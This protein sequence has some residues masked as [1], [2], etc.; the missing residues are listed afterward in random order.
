MER[1]IRTMADIW[2]ARIGT[3]FGWFWCVLYALA[4]VVAFC[5]LP[6]AKDR[7]DIAM[8]FI[9]IGLA[10]V[11]FLIVRASR[12]TRKLVCDFRIYAQ[13][14]ADDKSISALSKNVGEPREEVEKK[15]V[16]MCRRG[17]FKG[18]IDLRQECL[19]LDR[20]EEAVAARCP[21]CGATSRIYRTGGS[22]RYCGNPLL[23]G[24]TQEEKPLVQM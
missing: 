24:K 23:P 16:T 14:L 7:L 13:F 19:V 15:L 17:Y 4:A 5:D 20:P 11:H 6:D 3:A 1:R 18:K 9:C 12:Q 2:I 21:A 22:C 8:P 10:I